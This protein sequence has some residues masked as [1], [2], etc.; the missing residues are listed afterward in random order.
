MQFEAF[1]FERAIFS[2]DAGPGN[3]APFES[4]ALPAQKEKGIDK[5]TFGRLTGRFSNL[6]GA[7]H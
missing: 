2:P 6:P 3:G 1:E 7:A 5:H 4:V